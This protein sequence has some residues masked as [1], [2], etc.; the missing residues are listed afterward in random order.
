MLY[1]EFDIGPNAAVQAAGRAVHVTSIKPIFIAFQG[2]LAS[3]DVSG[4]AI[5]FTVD[6]QVLDCN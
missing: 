6:V 2:V 3:A 5:S 1:L 4:R